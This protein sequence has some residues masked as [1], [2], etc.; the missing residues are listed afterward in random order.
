MGPT[1]ALKYFRREVDAVSNP[2]LPIDVFGVLGESYRP[3]Y[4]RLLRY[5]PY[6]QFSK[7]GELLGCGAHGVVTGAIWHRPPSF[8]NKQLQDVPV[9]LKRIICGL[10]EQ[11]TFAKFIREVRPHIAFIFKLT[12]IV[13][14]VVRSF[15]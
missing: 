3:R 14:F 13:R 5:I 10:S 6:D 8:E 1:S 4:G 7:V 15:G 2:C 9:A 12:D 11:Q